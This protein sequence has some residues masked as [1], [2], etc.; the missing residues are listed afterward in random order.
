MISI[1]DLIYFVLAV[2]ALIVLWALVRCFFKRLS[3]CMR[4]HRV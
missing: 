2:I 1:A 3:C 4:I